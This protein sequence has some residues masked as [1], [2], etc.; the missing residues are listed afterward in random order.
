MNSIWSRTFDDLMTHAAEIQADSARSEQFAQMVF[1]LNQYAG[2]VVTLPPNGELFDM[3][4]KMTINSFTIWDGELQ[5]IGTGIYLSASLLDHSCEPNAV[6]TFHGNVLVVRTTRHIENP[7][8]TKLRISYIDQLATSAE[9]K[10]QLQEQYYFD[11]DCPRCQD[12]ELDDV[13]S[14]AQCPSKECEGYVTMSTEYVPVHCK[15][16]GCRDF[17]EDFKAFVKD[18]MLSCIKTIERIDEAKKQQDSKA[19]PSMYKECFASVKKVLYKHN[20]HLVKLLDRG[21]DAAIDEQ[22]WEM[23]LNYGVDTIESYK[24]LY[25]AMSPHIGI[26]LMKVGKLQLYLGDLTVALKSFHQSQDILRV[27][28]GEKQEIYT[29]LSSLI[30]QCEEELRMKLEHGQR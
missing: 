14:S 1:T 30:H 26:Q 6:V 16:C 12:T 3:F 5:G 7:K 23:A 17:S 20:I 24:K 22:Q 21:L 18:C 27:T 28:H 8:P 11:C 2:D 15:K 19:I 13:M 4:C 10:Q 29:E 25:P 9:R